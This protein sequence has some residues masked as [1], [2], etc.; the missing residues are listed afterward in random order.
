MSPS[1]HLG[2]GNIDL[3]LVR[4]RPSRWHF[5]RFIARTAAVKGNPFTLPQVEVHRVNEFSFRHDPEEEECS[6]KSVWNCDGEIVDLPEIRVRAHRQVVW[7]FGEGIMEPVASEQDQD[8]KT[9][10]KSGTLETIVD[11]DS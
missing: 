10:D 9:M 8:K 5:L 3:I 6:D 2:D 4:H 11:T 7:V 1:A